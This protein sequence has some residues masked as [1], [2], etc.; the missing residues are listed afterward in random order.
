MEV[1]SLI[2]PVWFISRINLIKMI[3]PPTFKTSR[4]LLKPVTEADI[5][6][7]EKH[8]IDYEV[9][10]H[11]AAAVPWPYPA[12]GV[13]KFVLDYILPTQGKNHWVWGIF[14]K[15]APDEL[16][17]VVDLWT[18]GKPEHRGFWLG[19]KFWGQGYMTE[20]VAPVNDFAFDQLGFEKLIFSNAKGNTH[21]HRVKVKTGARLLGNGAGK[22]VDPAYHETEEWELTKEE[23]DKYKKST[24][25]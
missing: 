8:F 18:P 22:F 20:A 16:I 12:D 4:L 23:W 13:R 25:R 9:I 21:S 15:Q 24:R 19:R 2:Q 14:L 3:Y 1:S 11:L 6:A 7:Y 17:G 10:R 5:P